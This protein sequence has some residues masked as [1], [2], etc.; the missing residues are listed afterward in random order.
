M[1]FGKILNIFI[2]PRCVN[3]GENV[4]AN[5]QLCAACWREITFITEPFCKTCGQPLDWEVPVSN[6]DNQCMSCYGHPPVY[7]QARSSVVYNEAA[8]KLL[9]RFKHGD[10]TH[11]AFIFAQWLKQS[12]ES[13]S[14]QA[15][16]L[17]PVP[18]HWTRL[19]Q[20]R[21]NQSALLAMSLLKVTDHKLTYAPYMLRRRR[22]TP[23]QGHKTTRQR[24]ENVKQA[25]VVPN[26]YRT[27]LKGKR[28]LLIDD[29]MTTGATLQ[30]CSRTL[31]QAGCKAVVI[32]TVARVLK[33]G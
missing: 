30:E 13:F 4:I 12:A 19:L 27:N 25:F 33:G 9:L 18:L 22:R 5:H 20:R 17:I 26:R 15:D 11:L 14:T 7:T 23:S 6:S 2:P 1:W 10:A 29:V 31:K 3:C 24:Y 16:Y 8:K 32:L 21:Y 28:V